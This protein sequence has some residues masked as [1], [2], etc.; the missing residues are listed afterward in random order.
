[1]LAVFPV[2]VLNS[3]SSS[4]AARLCTSKNSGLLLHQT[5]DKSGTLYLDQRVEF[6]DVQSLADGQVKHSAEVFYAGS[7]WKVSCVVLNLSILLMA[8]Q[9]STVI[10]IHIDN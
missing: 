5:S 6:E 7:L 10:G 3:D 8:Y 2:Y 4:I 9:L 1:M